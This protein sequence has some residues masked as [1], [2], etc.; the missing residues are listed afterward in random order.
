[1]SWFTDWQVSKYENESE[2]PVGS[3]DTTSASIGVVKGETPLI[4]DKAVATIVKSVSQL[5]EP[6]W[7]YFWFVQSYDAYQFPAFRWALILRLPV[8]SCFHVGDPI[9]AGQF[10]NMA[11]YVNGPET[12]NLDWKWFDIF[13][14]WIH[15]QSSLMK[16]FY[17]NL[18]SVKL[19]GF[20]LRHA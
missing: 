2:T 20:F 15:F 1:M 18:D 19:R 16:L 3:A 10:R 6:N 8:I 4:E 13:V 12:N 9:P 7:T 5:T 14:S 11:G 17:R